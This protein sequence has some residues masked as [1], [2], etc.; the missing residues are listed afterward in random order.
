MRNSLQ[1]QFLK[2]GLASDKQV[3]SVNKNKQQE[4][5][6]QRKA[7]KSQVKV[8][9]EAQQRLKQAQ[10]EQVAR[11]RELNLQRLEETRRKEVNAQIK[12]IIEQ[13]RQPR[14]NGDA[15]YQFVDGRK[16]KKLYFTPAVRDQLVRGQLALAK[17]AEQQYELIPP[18]AAEKIHAR[19]P[20]RLMVWNKPEPKPVPE[21]DDPYAGYEIP[22]DLMW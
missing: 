18:V 20:G 17:L 2:A 10:D 14:G 4:Q 19:D 15:V 5:K 16:V 12:Q 8:P 21:A 22:D 1:E 6:Q 11:D 7:P 13:S 3:K 9:D